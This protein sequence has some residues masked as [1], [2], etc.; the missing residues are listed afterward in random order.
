MHLKLSRYLRKINK[1]H[2]LKDN[3][4]L[5]KLRKE[6]HE[7]NKVYNLSDETLNKL[8]KKCDEIIGKYESH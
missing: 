7:A 1:I 3:P 6:I 5:L 4:E 8:V 2:G